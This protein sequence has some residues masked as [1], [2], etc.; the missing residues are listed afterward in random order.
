M[1]FQHNQPTDY[2][3]FAKRWSEE[4]FC[5]ICLTLCYQ[6]DRMM[7]SYLMNL[8]KS[9]ITEGGIKERMHA[10]RT[11]YREAQ[12]LHMKSLEET[13]KRQAQRI[14]ELEEELKRIKDPL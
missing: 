8:E 6:I 3:A 2:L 14:K 1:D 5:N 4:E 12:E 11:G 7:N 9:F 10:A 13:V